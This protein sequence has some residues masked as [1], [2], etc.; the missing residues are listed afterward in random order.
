MKFFISSIRT[1]LFLIIFLVLIGSIVA[2][3]IDR[4]QE[5]LLDLQ[6]Q[7]FT[8][9]YVAI[10]N[11]FILIR[12]ESIPDE[13]LN[14]VM[15]SIAKTACDKTG[16]EYIRVEAYFMEEPI[17]ALN[18]VCTDLKKNNYDTLVFEDIRNPEFK[19]ESD[20]AIFDALIQEVKI[21]KAT[22][23]ISLEYLADEDSFWNDYVAMALLVVE[24]APWV[25]KVVFEYI[26]DNDNKTLIISDKDNILKLLSGEIS[27]QVFVDQ[28]QIQQSGADTILTLTPTSV[29]PLVPSLT[30]SISTTI[31]VTTI[32][33]STP[34]PTVSSSQQGKISDS[35]TFCTIDEKGNIFL[36]EY[37]KGTVVTI[38]PGGE[39]TIIA[40]GIDKPRFPVLDSLGNLYVGSF[41]GTIQKI[42]PDGT[43]TLIGS[44]IWSPQ[45]MGV[46]GT[47]TLYIA[48]GYDGKIYKITQS[49]TMSSVNSGVKNPKSLV[50]TQ[51]GGIYYA[52]TD[53]LI[54]QHI[55]QEGNLASLANVGKPIKGMA[56]E[57]DT[58]YVCYDDT[59]AQ[60]D[61]YGKVI[62]VMQNLNQPTW[63]AIRNGQICVAQKDGTYILS[64]GK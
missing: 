23:S 36:A 63:I 8:D 48:G 62:P 57:G 35:P 46:D 1:S 18:A 53:G 10:E 26:G 52:D 51:G 6:N 20:L 40:S 16:L 38:S 22:A 3:D 32:P 60:I 11:P 47:D 28:L 44:G 37:S 61:P 31:I 2:G 29:S 34:T 50:V 9:C 56:I 41:D 42:S 24:D 27:A 43:K 15:F 13:N 49:R 12:F 30:P 39:Q 19:I 17:F 45:G 4:E 5:I 25:D 14:D 55:T 64:R 58:I 7:G 21:D 54:I 59:I 33:T